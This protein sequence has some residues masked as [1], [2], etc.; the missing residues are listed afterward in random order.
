M[1]A[2]P[3]SATAGDEDSVRPPHPIL[4]QH[5]A[6]DIL[7]VLR[8]DTSLRDTIKKLETELSVYK[9]AFA[10][11]EGELKNSRLAYLEAQ[12]GNRVVILLDGD[13]AIF[14]GQHISKGREGGHKAAQILSDATL[15]CLAQ[16]F[17]SRSF[18]LWAFVFFNKRGLVDTFRRT[19]KGTWAANLDEFV[20]GFN[21]STERFVMVDVGGMKEAADAKLKAYL[22]HEIRLPETFKVVFGACHDN[23]YVANLHSQIT[24]GFK[25]KLILLKSYTEMAAGIAAL[26]LPTLTI[27]DLFMLNKI[28]DAVLPPSPKSTTSSASLKSPPLSGKVSLGLAVSRPLNP[29]LP[30][31]KR[32]TS[33][34]TS[35]SPLTQSDLTEHPAPC[36]SHYLKNSCPFPLDCRFAHDYVLSTAQV[37]E[38]AKSAKRAPCPTALKGKKCEND[39]DC[40][41]GHVCPAGANCFFQKKAKCRFKHASMH[42]A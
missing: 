32:G 14:S 15:Q 26:S 18:Q 19:G 2:K 10:D 24:A 42:P 4:T 3:P 37:L 13:G 5:I 33:A 34:D 40:I 41:Y 11:V 23:G 35:P 25:E 39:E 21:Q 16:N 22:E 7:E 20:L 31:T 9:R 6:D 36:T 12:S 1:E 27:E 8:N 17:G 38:L 28:G 29:E 30:L